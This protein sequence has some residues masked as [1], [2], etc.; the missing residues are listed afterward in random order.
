[1]LEAA[2]KLIEARGLPQVIL[3]NSNRELMKHLCENYKSFQLRPL[4]ETCLRVMLKSYYRLMLKLRTEQRL[5]EIDLIIS[6]TTAN[7]P[8]DD[9]TK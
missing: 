7:K 8:N 6:F 1:M 5:P 2:E 3:L 9:T 4:V